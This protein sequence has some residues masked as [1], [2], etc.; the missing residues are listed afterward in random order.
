MRAAALPTR[1]RLP[2]RTQFVLLLAALV[3]SAAA[4]QTAPAGARQDAGAQ[5]PAPAPQPGRQQ[6]SERIR[7]EDAGSRVDELRVGGQTQRISV[8]PKTGAMP[9]YEVQPRAGNG[10]ANTGARVWTVLTF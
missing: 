8:Q 7:I 6:R 4:A 10:D 1:P 3:C 5:Q 9:G 2:V